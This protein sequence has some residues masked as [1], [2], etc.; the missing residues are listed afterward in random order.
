ME[1]DSRKASFS[2]IRFFLIFRRGA[3]EGEG[4]GEAEGVVPYWP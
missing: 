1:A 3:G 2:E 4:E